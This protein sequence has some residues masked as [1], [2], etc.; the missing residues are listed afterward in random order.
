MSVYQSFA[1]H[2]H[3]GPYARFS[4]RITDEI[5]PSLCAA[6]D[7]KPQSLL[8][9]ACGSG[10]FAIAMAKKGLRVT[11]LDQSASLLE[12][13]RR[14]ADAAAVNVAWV[15]GNMAG[16]HLDRTF[17]C[18]TCFFDSL[19]Y[20]IRLK[21]LAGAVEHA[22]LHLEPGGYFIFDMNTIYGLAVLWQRNKTSIVQD[23]P[24]YMEVA[25]NSFNFETSIAEMRLVMFE[26]AGEY[27]QRFEESHLE[28]GYTVDD[29]L[30]LLETAGFELVH[31]AGNPLT[32]AP[33]GELDG[34]MWVVARKPV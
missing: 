29:I 31:L 17:D 15:E 30:L 8:D 4:Q 14:E 11:G 33:L 16:F 20:L 26:K 12:I 24:D 32:L 9:L 25:E 3:V 22:C 23:L 18:V 5:F 6:L 27:W 10:G 1:S 34:R 21:D 2:Y 28:R 7:F 13:A 19:N